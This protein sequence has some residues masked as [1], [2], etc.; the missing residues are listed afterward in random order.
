MLI[1]C[2]LIATSWTDYDLQVRHVALLASVAFLSAADPT[3]LTQSVSLSMSPMLDTLPFLSNSLSQLPLG[4]S[5]SDS[6]LAPKTSNYHYLS[7][8]LS[9]LTPLTTSHPILFAP[10]VQT[11][12]AFLSS[13]IFPPVDCGPMPTVG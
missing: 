12:L 10:H 8:F 4:S 5:S 2:S 9:T 6:S 13:L 7:I 3:Q 1:L 11:L